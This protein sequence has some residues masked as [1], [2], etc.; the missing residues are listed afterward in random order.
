MTVGIR[1]VAFIGGASCPPCDQFLAVMR[2]KM[3]GIEITVTEDRALFRRHRV[4][5]APTFIAFRQ[6]WE[7]DRL[8]GWT[9]EKDFRNWL[10]SFKK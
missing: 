9:E 3:E 6:G 7:I 8:V 1:V 2:P 10:R 4:E 5:R